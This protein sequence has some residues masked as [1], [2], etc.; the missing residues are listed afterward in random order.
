MEK[1]RMEIEGLMVEISYEYDCGCNGDDDTPSTAPSVDIKHWQL[2]NGE[3]QERKNYPD[4]TDEEWEDWMDD[5]E[6]YVFE[7]SHWDIV[8]FEED[9]VLW[10]I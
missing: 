5:I 3:K 6:R 4:C 10:Q 1:Y 2:V 9:L 7:D 8:E